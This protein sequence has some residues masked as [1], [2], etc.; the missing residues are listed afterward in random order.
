[1][2]MWTS[3]SGGQP[4]GES[5]IAHSATRRRDDAP[6]RASGSAPHAAH[7]WAP[8]VPQRGPAPRPTR[9]GARGGRCALRR[10][11]LELRLS[12]QIEA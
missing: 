12:L 6:G 7:S 3:A 11:A 5:R 9:P 10:L 8:P 1:M 2:E 4:V